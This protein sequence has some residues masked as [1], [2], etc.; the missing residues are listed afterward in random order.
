MKILITGWAGYIGSHTVHYLK[1]QWIPVEDLIIFDN[2]VYGHQESLP[3]WVVFIKWDLLNKTEIN[4][5]FENHK[6][7]AVIHFAAYAFVWESMANPGKYFENNILAWVNL[8]EAMQK[9]HCKYIVFSST[10]A[11]YWSPDIVP[12]TETET[13]NPINPYWE[14]KLMF[15]KILDY[16]DQ[17]FW[18]KSVKLRYFNASG[19]GYGIGESHDPETHLIPLVLQ[20]AL[21]Q[22]EHIKIFGTDYNT[23]DGTCIRDYI[24][25]IDL[26]DAHYKSIQYLQKENT[27][28]FF[29]LGTWKWTSV[30]EIID[31]TKEITKIDFA[32]KIA[33]K[34]PWDPPI[35]I[36]SNEKVKKVLWRSPKKTA[37]E[38]VEDAWEWSKGG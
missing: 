13:Q 37:R 24:H 27:S 16:Y 21:W 6:I 14:S 8:L 36:A 5:V 28:N 19:A 17:I 7:D 35:L 1:E 4:K 15:E 11:T 23:P 2:L 20:T 38:S 29:N 10:C 3:Q 22:R 18:I 25:V 9:N 26:A 31:L 12:I 30:K 34:R 33:E 32:V